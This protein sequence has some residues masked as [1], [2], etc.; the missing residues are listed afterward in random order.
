[1]WLRAAEPGL[2]GEWVRSSSTVCLRDYGA[3]GVRFTPGFW[4]DG[5]QTCIARAGAALA[6]SSERWDDEPG[7]LEYWRKCP[8]TLVLMLIQ[9][10]ALVCVQRT[11]S[12]R[13]L[14]FSRL[15]DSQRQFGPIRAVATFGWMCGC[16]LVSGL[17]IDA[18][19]RAGYTGALVWLS[20]AAFT[21][22]LP[23]VAPPPSGRLTWRERMVGTAWC[24]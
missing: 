5:R 9:L 22:A 4:G 19:P 1:M 12:Q 7:E 11:A 6:G 13:Q 14:F 20:L 16:W 2:D 23:S 8:T 15:R 3:S 17:N 10:Y 18:S 21:Y 24:C